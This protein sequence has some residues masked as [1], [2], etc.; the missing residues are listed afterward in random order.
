MQNVSCNE[1]DD[2]VMDLRGMED[3][4][5]LM[6]SLEYYGDGPD[7]YI[8]RALRNSITETKRKLMDTMGD[9]YEAPEKKEEIDQ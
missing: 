4:L 1:L 7:A 3:L 9:Y 2:V 6:A 5:T 8:C